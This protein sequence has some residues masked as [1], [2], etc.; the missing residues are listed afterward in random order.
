MD[1][2]KSLGDAICAVPC[3]KSTTVDCCLYRQL[4][5]DELL[6]VRDMQLLF[7]RD[8]ILV[9]VLK[10]QKI[11]LIKYSS[12]IHT[13]SCPFS[14]FHLVPLASSFSFFHLVPLAYPFSFFD[15]VPLAFF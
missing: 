5:D 3:E 4:C 6:F 11:V 9:T 8:K 1:I 15:L 2:N 14:F 13:S 10:R 7:L 12:D